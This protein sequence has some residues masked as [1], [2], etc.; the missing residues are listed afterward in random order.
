MVMEGWGHQ[1]PRTWGWTVSTAGD[2]HADL[3]S[4]T[5]VGMDLR[6]RPRPSRRTAKP[7]ARGD[8]PPVAHVGRGTPGQAP[9]TWG[10]TVARPPPG[11]RGGPSPTH[12]GMDRDWWWCCCHRCAK[13]HARGDG[14][15]WFDAADGKVHQAPRTWGWTVVDIQE[16]ERRLPSP[17]HVGMDRH[18][19]TVSSSRTAKPHARG[20]GPFRQD[21]RTGRWDQAPRTWGWTGHHPVDQM[22][23]LPSP[24][25]V[26]MDRSSGGSWRPGGT[27]PHARGDG[28][29]SLCRA[30]P[31]PV[32]APRTWGWTGT[33]V[34]LGAVFGLFQ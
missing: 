22:P 4:P 15:V 28:P 8:G 29:S 30:C 32:R 7:H 17:T 9:R 5:H 10:W 31:R 19:E 6:A 1:A 2:D 26:G 20:D 14:P 18:T 16:L 3:P 27:K 25:H 11:A 12:V 21:A 23:R 13:P 33:A 34:L 24:T